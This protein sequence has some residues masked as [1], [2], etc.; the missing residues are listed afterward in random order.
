MTD[1]KP[2]GT[3]DVLVKDQYGTPVYHPKNLT[4]KLLSDI[5]GTKTLTTKTLKAALLL[6]YEINYQREEVKL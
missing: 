1:T 6:G 4:A 3:V 2:I 5:A